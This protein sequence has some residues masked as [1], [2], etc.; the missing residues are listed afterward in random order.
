[1]KEHDIT[2]DGWPVAPATT[3]STEPYSSTTAVPILERAFNLD[4]VETTCTC[5]NTRISCNGV[6]VCG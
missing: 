5:I 6:P 3:L 4:T 1:M 2:K